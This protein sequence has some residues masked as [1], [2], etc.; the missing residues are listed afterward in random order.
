MDEVS[1]WKPSFSNR[2]LSLLGG[3]KVYIEIR[4]AAVF[5]KC[6]LLTCSPDVYHVNMY[7][8]LLGFKHMMLI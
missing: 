6:L 5:V 1:L 2:Q 3:I 4:A 7:L 8:E